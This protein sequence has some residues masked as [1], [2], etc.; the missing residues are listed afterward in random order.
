MKDEIFREMES[1]GL[2]VLAT[3]P[4]ISE[5]LFV[6]RANLPS[7]QVE[8]L[9]NALLTLKDKTHGADILRSINISATALVP[10]SNSDYAN[11][12]VIVNSLGTLAP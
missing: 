4:A 6:T 11:L 2:R 12:R 3:S 9:R 5:H 8:Q 1:Q 10:V 7:A